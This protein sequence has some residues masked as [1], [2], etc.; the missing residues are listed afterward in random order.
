MLS[1]ISSLVTLAL[2]L[3]PTSVQ[4]H[5][6]IAL[7]KQVTDRYVAAQTAGD[8]SGLN[9]SST[10]VYT[11]NFQPADIAT[12][13]LS[14][15]LKIDNA[16][17]IHDT[18]ECSTFTQL[19]VTDP[20]HPYVIGTQIR[21]PSHGGGG[22]IAK[23]ETLVTD[24][25]DWLFN[26]TGTL[27]WTQRENWYEIPKDQQ[28]SRETLRKAADAY[29]N[30]FTDNTVRVPFHFPCARLEGGIYTGTGSDTDTCDVGFPT[31]IPML[32]RRYVI[33]Q[34]YGAINVMFNFGG[35]TH[36]PDSHL[37]RLE[38]SGIRYVHTMTVLKCNDLPE[39]PCNA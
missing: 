33:D 3:I 20:T 17:S 32:N 1:S 6:S 7:L 26:A 31:G 18:S 5:C 30:K 19:V 35:P 22:E 11:E 34:A 23:V 24:Q 16:H 2:V 39:A 21:L 28:D 8:V 36:S 25:G 14:Q 12:G 29:L 27:Y 13:I 9:F 37:F 4:A 15:S 38:K 10:G